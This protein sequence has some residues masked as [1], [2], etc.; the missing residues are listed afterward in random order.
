MIV[1]SE[2]LM[3][4]L[5]ILFAAV[6]EMFSANGRIVSPGGEKKEG[7]AHG[8]IKKYIRRSNK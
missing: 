2:P 5:C 8:L 6:L 7:S 1:T 3:I 4:Y